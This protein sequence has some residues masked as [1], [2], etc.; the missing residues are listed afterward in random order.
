MRR[1]LIKLSL[2]S[3][4]SAALSSCGLV[5]TPEPLYYWG[6]TVNGASEYE[7]LTYRDYKKQSPEAICQLICAYEKMVK[8]PGGTRKVP[9]PGV[10]AEY[11]YLLL[12]PET[13]VAFSEKASTAQRQVFEGNDYAALFN[14]RA[15]EVL[16]MELELYPE[17]RTFLEPLVKKWTTK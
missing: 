9:P 10:C 7:N 14:E 3:F 17:S 16:Q 8:H 6:S 12:L 13:A 15:K 11:G 2:I 4:V 1:G 5:S